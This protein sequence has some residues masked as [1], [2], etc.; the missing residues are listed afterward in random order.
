MARVRDLGFCVRCSRACR[1]QFC[2]RDQGKG[3][4]LKTDCRLGWAGCPAC[5]ELVGS[6]GKLGKAGRRDEEDELARRTRAEI[7]R[8]GWWPKNLPAVR[9]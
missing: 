3:T 7:R 4:G 8:R 9:E 1:P 2:H 5:H 6:T